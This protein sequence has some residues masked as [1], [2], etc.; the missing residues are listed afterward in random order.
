M[1]GGVC[2]VFPGASSN[3]FGY[4]L[5]VCNLVVKDTLVKDNKNELE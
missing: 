3:R 2:C 4:S 5:G 1:F